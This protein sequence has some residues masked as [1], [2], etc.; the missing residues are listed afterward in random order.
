MDR[1]GAP[2]YAL[3]ERLDSGE[4]RKGIELL[5][6]SKK[7]LELEQWVDSDLNGWFGGNL[8]PVTRAIADRWGIL[9]AL[10]QQNG[11]PLGNI[12]GMLA[13]TA[14]EHN[15][16]VATRNTRHFAG[17]GVTLLNPWQS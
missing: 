14:L 11:K 2:G 1:I 6:L 9:A 16:T 10:S 7:R 12:D 5:P 17:L 4:I 13:A 3:Y 15:L 8:L